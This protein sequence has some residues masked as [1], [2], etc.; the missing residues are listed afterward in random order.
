MELSPVRGCGGEAVARWGQT[1]EMESEFPWTLQRE[2][3]EDHQAASMTPLQCVCQKPAKAPGTAR[4]L[5]L[6]LEVAP[7]QTS[8]ALPWV[9][10]V[11][12]R[13]FRTPGHLG[14]RYCPFLQKRHRE[15][16]GAWRPHSTGRT[17]TES[18][19]GWS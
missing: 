15:A 17:K 12:S 19:P 2:S 9:Q 14:A 1:W 3:P 13:C 11:G 7:K 5:R 10:A 18:V 16:E 4:A 6:G 8:Q